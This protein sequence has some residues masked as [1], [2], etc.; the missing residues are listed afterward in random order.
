MSAKTLDYIVKTVM[1]DLGESSLS[2]YQTYLQF[3]IRGFRELSLHNGN[4]NKIAYLP[5]KSNKAVD[6]PTD[7]IKYTKIGVCINGRIVTLG[8]DDS[9]C[10]NHNFDDC[11]DPI[12]I[13]MDSNSSPEL[14]SNLNYGYY[15]L[16]HFH[17]G[18]YVAGEYGLGG[19]YNG[20]GYYRID[21]EQNQIQLT[22]QIPSTEIVLEY[23]ADG[24]SPD[25]TAAVPVEA[26]ECLIAWVHW[27]RQQRKSKVPQG[28]K[29][30]ARRDYIVEFNKL[31]HFKLMFTEQEL[32]DAWRKNIHSAVKR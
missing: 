27:K 23:I 17:N 20:L 21:K 9:L 28:E 14:I 24:L 1:A 6:L 30:A 4:T 16:D 31:R 12:A 18:Q 5:I 25:G 7:Y 32:L 15:F 3:A 2:N 19:G 29:E 10:I 8:L 13:A 11:G 22:S 26:V